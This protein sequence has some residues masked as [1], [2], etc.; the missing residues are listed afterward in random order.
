M[1][2]RIVETAVY[3]TRAEEGFL[4]LLDKESNELYLRAGKGLGRTLAA[5]FRIKSRDSL[6]WQVI[7]SGK[8]AM[9]DGPDGDDRSKIKTDYLVKSMLH[10]PLKVD[11]A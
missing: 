6:A 9:F 1:F 2:K 11:G 4:L 8:P 3:V 7:R 10:V 5:G